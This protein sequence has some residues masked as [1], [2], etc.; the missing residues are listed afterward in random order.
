MKNLIIITGDLAS[1][2]STLC[3][4]L[5]IKHKLF[6]LCKDEIKENLVDSIDF[7]SREDNKKLSLAS[8]N[9]MSFVMESYFKVHD[10]IILE[11]NFRENEL[12][13]YLSFCQN[14]DINITIINLIGDIDVLY[15]RFLL[16]L[17]TRHKAHTSL[18]L[19]NS[20]ELFKD[21]LKSLRANDNKLLSRFNTIDITNLN[22]DEVLNISEQL[23]NSKGVL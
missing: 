11:A 20:I 19:D 21:Y 6:Y 17:T 8:V 3:K 16:R 18:K 1:G 2:K 14:S 13:N 22:K 12:N 7:T 23:L 5:A 15:S 10:T 4:S 9:I